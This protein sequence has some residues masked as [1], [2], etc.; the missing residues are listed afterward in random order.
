MGKRSFDATDST[1]SSHSGSGTWRG[2]N[3]GAKRIATLLKEAPKYSA[4]EPSD[5]FA[6]VANLDKFVAILVKDSEVI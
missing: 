2:T 1:G 6:K 3:P 4:K 5:M